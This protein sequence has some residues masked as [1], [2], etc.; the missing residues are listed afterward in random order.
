MCHKWHRGFLLYRVRPYVI[1]ELCDITTNRPLCRLIDT[2]QCIGKKL[3]L[4]SKA[5]TPH[6]T[7]K[8]VLTYNVSSDRSS[9]PTSNPIVSQLFFENLASL[10]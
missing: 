7:R 9:R 10:S 6:L 2:R 4:C 3:L 5:D 8:M 1:D